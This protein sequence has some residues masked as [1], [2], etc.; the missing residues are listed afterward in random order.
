[1]DLEK[2]IIQ[3]N[4]E[5][6]KTTNQ[7]KELAKKTTTVDKLG[8]CYEMRRLFDEAT[9]L[10]E[11]LEAIHF[12]PNVKLAIIQNFTSSL[13]E[14]ARSTETIPGRSYLL[15]RYSKKFTKLAIKA[16]KYS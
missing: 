16:K 5:V 13:L 7:A 11:E 14:M 6:E 10:I 2:R 9:L 3:F 12:K 4:S 8:L 1:M 15:P